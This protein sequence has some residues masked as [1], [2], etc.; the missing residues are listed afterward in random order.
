MQVVEVLRRCAM[1]ILLH[2]EW[3]SEGVRGVLEGDK[4]EAEFTVV[5]AESSSAFLDL[6]GKAVVGRT[7]DLETLVDFDR[8]L[9]IAGTTF[10]RIQYLGGLSILISFP[11]EALAEKFLKAR[12]LWGP[13]FS[14]LDAW[15]GQSLLFERVAWLRLHGIPMH[16]VDPFVLRSIGDSFGKVL[17]VPKD[18]EDK[19]D[20]SVFRVGVLAGESK[21]IK[22][23][24]NLKW[25]N[26]IFRIWVEEE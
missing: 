8:L 9:N 20:L 16:L 3:E 4:V 10:S 11:D 21:R 17:H 2:P 22:E 25:K 6:Y 15:R 19:K 5:V 23:M 14:H 18:I 24:M 26:K 7:V 13:W 12:D 1:V